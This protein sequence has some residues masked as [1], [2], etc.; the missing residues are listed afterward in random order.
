MWQ[1]TVFKWDKTLKSFL[2]SPQPAIIVKSILFRCQ[3]SAILLIFKP[4]F[5][6]KFLR[7]LLNFR[8]QHNIK[9]MLTYQQASCYI[10]SDGNI[11]ASQNPILS[12]SAEFFP[13][14]FISRMQYPC[15]YVYAR[16]IISVGGRTFSCF[17]AYILAINV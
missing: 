12:T 1:K 8:N 2:F 16:K 14:L 3:N 17:I 5:L 6:K 4:S 7:N 15:R 10:W 9:E 11:E 13:P